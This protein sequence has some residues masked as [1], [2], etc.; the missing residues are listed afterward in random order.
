MDSEEAK[1][2]LNKLANREMEEFRINKEEFLSF[3]EVLVQRAD[4]K[5]FR[6]NAQHNGEV[7]YTYLE[8]AR[9]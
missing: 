3:R 9:S 6:G 5:H 1:L 8:E 4:F 7:I 2:V